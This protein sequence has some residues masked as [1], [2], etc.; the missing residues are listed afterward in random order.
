MEQ[1]REVERIIEEGKNKAKKAASKLMEAS[2]DE[3]ESKS[4]CGLN[5]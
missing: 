4:F 1:C 3:P 5:L 2:D